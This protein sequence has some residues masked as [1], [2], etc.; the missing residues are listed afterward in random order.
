[1][2]SA[3]FREKEQALQKKLREANANKFDVEVPEF[4]PKKQKQK[5]VNRKYKKKPAMLEYIEAQERR[6]SF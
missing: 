3:E 4:A 2:L 6:E 5:Y 1:M